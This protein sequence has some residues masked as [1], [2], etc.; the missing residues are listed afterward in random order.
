[1]RHVILITHLRSLVANSR[2]VA[3]R[4]SVTHRNRR[5]WLVGVRN[6]RICTRTGTDGHD[7]PATVGD[8]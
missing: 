6:G 8:R 5:A 3:P 7:L 2:P 1:M 4:C